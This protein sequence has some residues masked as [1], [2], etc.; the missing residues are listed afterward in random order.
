MTCCARPKDTS[1]KKNMK[2]MAQ[3]FLVKRY[4]GEN[5]SSRG[6]GSRGDRIR[7]N[8]REREKREKSRPD[9]ERKEDQIMV[10]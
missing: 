2:G 7:S 9:R 1:V 5:I 4:H 6:Q 10:S 3:Q 8:Q